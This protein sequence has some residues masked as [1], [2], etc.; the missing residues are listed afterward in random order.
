MT[1]TN[2]LVFILAALLI[3]LAAGRWRGWLILGVSVLS[4]FWLQPG[5]PIRSL[6]FWLPVVSLALVLLGWGV[7]RRREDP[8]TRTD[9]V[10]CLVMLCLA[11]L[12][13]LLRYIDPLCCLTPTHPPVFYQVFAGLLLVALLAY[14][15]ARFA[16]SRPLVLILGIILIILI[17]VILKTEPLSLEA[18]QLL[19]QLNG[20]KVDLARAVDLRWL[21]FSYLAFR[22]LHT[23]RDRQLGR[24]PALSLPEYASY[25]LFFPALTAGPIDRA[26]R[27]AKDLRSQPTDRVAL[28]VDGGQRLVVGLFRKFVL[29]DL[30]G[31]VALS[32]FNYSQVKST[33]W[34]WLMLYAYAF[35]IYF[36]F[37]GYTD[38]VIGLGRIMGIR[39]P[40][41]FDR[42]YLKPNMTAF[43]NSWHMTLAQW[44]RGYFFNPLTRSLRVRRNPPPIFLVILLTQLA[45][46]ALIGLWHGVT[47]NFLIWG[48][49][50]GLGLFIHNRWLEFSRRHLDLGSKPAWLQRISIWAGIFL[51]FNFVALGWVWF[52]LPEPAQ[53][54]QVLLRLFGIV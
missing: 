37:S 35:R 44:F 38:I 8:L 36:D 42:P 54:W 10:A 1:L 9:L 47:W 14:C 21:G 7:T 3:G 51:T 16:A 22:L 12:A 17:F 34:M 5:T 28:L 4:L 32:Q 11:L 53:S 24:L 41:N 39:L 15:A 2:I 19:R 26:E 23:L 40:E 52:V 6:D 49:W 30:L 29:A 27:F 50:H 13:G 31:L 46:M 25:M 45:T 18:S 20:Q 33:G 48:L 43:W